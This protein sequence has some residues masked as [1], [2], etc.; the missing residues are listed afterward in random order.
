MVEWYHTEPSLQVVVVAAGRGNKAAGE[1]QK[2]GVIAGEEGQKVSVQA[3]FAGKRGLRWVGSLGR[4]CWLQIAA[5]I[6]LAQLGNIESGN[7]L[8][9]PLLQRLLI[10]AKHDVQALVLKDLR[11]KL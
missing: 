5:L 10:R 9:Q 11:V 8:R 1:G 2:K 7:G 3:I 6:I 4:G